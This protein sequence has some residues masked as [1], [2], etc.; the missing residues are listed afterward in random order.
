[1]SFPGAWTCS[2][3]QAAPKFR[4]NPY[5]THSYI[6]ISFPSIV[7]H[8]WWHFLH[9][10]FKI[11]GTS[12]TISHTPCYRHADEVWS[13]QSLL[14]VH[15]H[16]EAEHPLSGRFSSDWEVSGVFFTQFIRSGIRGSP[17]EVLKTSV[18]TIFSPCGTCDR[19]QKKVSFI[20][21]GQYFC[22]KHPRTFWS[23]LQLIFKF[24]Q[25]TDG[26]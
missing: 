18:T 14:L 15:Q 4:M 8:E 20:V 7:R 9:F 24:I 5:T 25:V 1:M 17:V 11:Y 3:V 26:K 23:A 13:I 16:L 22:Q 6:Q 21:L 19:T 2:L 10:D 12:T